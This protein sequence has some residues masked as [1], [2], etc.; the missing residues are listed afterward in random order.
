MLNSKVKFVYTS[1]DLLMIY[2]RNKCT[3][4]LVY[5]TFPLCSVV[6]AYIVNHSGLTFYFQIRDIVSICK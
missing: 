1:Y 6:I 3:M 5:L 2:A 4:T